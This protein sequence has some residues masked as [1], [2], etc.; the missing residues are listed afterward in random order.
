LSNPVHTTICGVKNWISEENGVTSRT[1]KSIYFN[2]AN[3]GWAVG[4]LGII[5]KTTNGGNNW[6]IKPSGTSSLL[7]SVYF[8]DAYIG[9]AVGVSGT[10]VVSSDGGDNW[11]TQVSSTTNDLSSVYISESTADGVDAWIC[12]DLGTVLKNSENNPLPIELFSF[13]YE[14]LDN[15][16]K[17]KWVTNYEQNNKGF[18]IYRNTDNDNWQFIGFKE[19]KGTTNSMTSYTFEDK[20]L[21]SG[22]YYYKLKQIDYNGNYK[23]FDLNGAVE[24]GVPKKFILSQNYPNPCNPITNIEFQ[25]PSAS[26]VSLKVFD[27]TGREVAILINGES[28]AANYYIVEFDASYLSSGVYFYTLI[29]DGYI[30]VKKMFLIK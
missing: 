29:T 30:A 20:K 13:S 4:Y 19:G 21:Y 17:L 15:N 18:E 26:K 3:T 25:I 16:V 5:L 28:R 6:I 9:C 22:K 7:F 24:I 1:F 11:T 8:S 23:Y 12:G 14:I 10:I 27:I 2:N